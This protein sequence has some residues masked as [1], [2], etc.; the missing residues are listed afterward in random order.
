MLLAMGFTKD[1]AS[2]MG[3]KGGRPR[4]DQPPPPTVDDGEPTAA[5]D[6]VLR[7]REIIEWV[8]DNLGEKRCPPAPNRKA[9]EL[10]KYAKANPN[11]FLDKYVPLLV[12]RD[13]EVEKQNEDDGGCDDVLALI[14]KCLSDFDKAHPNDGPKAPPHGPLQQGSQVLPAQPGVPGPHHPAMQGR[15]RP[16]AGNDRLVI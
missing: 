7:Y 11:G 5:G 3:K 14:D 8:W 13:K 6:D 9:R 12:A 16:A 10:W 2:D 15:P 4:K 1:N